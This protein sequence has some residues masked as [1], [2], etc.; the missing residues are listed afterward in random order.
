VRLAESVG[1]AWHPRPES[2]LPHD[3]A[4]PEDKW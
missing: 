1:V 3:W 2:K 4:D